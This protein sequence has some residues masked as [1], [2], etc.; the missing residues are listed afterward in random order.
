VKFRYKK[1]SQGIIRPVIP[2]EIIYGNIELPYEVLVDSG[3]DRNIFDAQTARILGLDLESG[4]VEKVS[5][6]AGQEEKYYGHHMDLR[7]GGHLFKNVEVGFLERIGTFGYGVVG[8]KGFFD[9]FAVKFDL[10]KE[11]V[12]LKPY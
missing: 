2:I 6:I 5:G 1:Y 3:A 12:E 8:Q 9:L 10:R 11:E 4:A 7:I